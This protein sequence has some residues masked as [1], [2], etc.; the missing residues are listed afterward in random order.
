MSSFR[1]AYDLQAGLLEAP[2]A[3]ACPLGLTARSLEG[4]AGS[5]AFRVGLCDLRRGR[6]QPI[7]GAD[8]LLVERFH[9][10]LGVHP[11]ALGFLGGA[12]G[13]GEAVI[14]P[15]D[16]RVGVLRGLSRRR[17]LLVLPG[18]TRPGVV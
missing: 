17:Q 12:L 18:R 7:V 4:L 5:L 14:R 6:T 16:V 11:P 8:Q 9:P 10:L 2:D 15:L 1:V 13:R 3:G